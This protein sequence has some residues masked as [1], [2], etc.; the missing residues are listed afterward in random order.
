M[1]ARIFARLERR[2]ARR[3]RV[4][5]ADVARAERLAAV[6]ADA[7]LVQ[8]AAAVAVAQHD[9]GTRGGGRVAIAPAQELDDHRPQVEAL[10]GEAVLVALGALLVGD[11]PQDALRDEPLQARG[12]HVARDAEVA[13][14]RVEAAHAEEDVA[15]DEHRPALADELERARD[16]AVLVPVVAAQHPATHSTI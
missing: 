7:P 16:R 10:L 1:H 6:L 2:R 11:L 4:R 15:Q 9:W 14:D 8:Q 12:E 3:D 5:P 13:L